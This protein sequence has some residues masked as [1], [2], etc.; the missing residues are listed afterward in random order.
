MLG[1]P[2]KGSPSRGGQTTPRAPGGGLAAP[3]VVAYGHPIDE[4]GG[5]EVAA[6]PVYFFLFFYII[7]FEF[8]K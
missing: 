3:W 7:F 1:L 2:D 4:R 5:I 8:L 6:T